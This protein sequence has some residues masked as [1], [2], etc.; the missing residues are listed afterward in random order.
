MRVKPIITLA[1]LTLVALIQACSASKQT[2]FMKDY[3]LQ[4]V[5]YRITDPQIEK[6]VSEAQGRSLLKK[7]QSY[8]NERLGKERDRLHELVRK[9]VYENFDKNFIHFD[10]DTTLASKRYVVETIIGTR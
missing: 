4:A 6:I 10:V 8:S 7:G 3:K 5:T 9:K 2:T 1:L